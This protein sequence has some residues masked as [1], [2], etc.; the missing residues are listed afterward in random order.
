MAELSYPII[1]SIQSPG[2]VILIVWFRLE[3]NMNNFLGG[4]STFGDKSNVQSHCRVRR[5]AP[6]Q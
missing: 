6:Y 5:S 1:F 3:V 2:R 4:E